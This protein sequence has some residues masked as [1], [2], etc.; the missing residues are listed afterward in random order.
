MK[1]EE[2]K[3][4]RIKKL[5]GTCVLNS[6]PSNSQIATQSACVF[7]LYLLIQEEEGRTQQC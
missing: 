7:Y 5:E 2:E 1:Y 4:L 3:E 6:L